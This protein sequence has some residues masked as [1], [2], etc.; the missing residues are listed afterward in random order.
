[1]KMIGFDPEAV[2]FFHGTITKQLSMVYD[3][4]GYERL[5]GL[6]T[7]TTKELFEMGRKFE[8]S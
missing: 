6:Y 3:R 4:V 2:E 8:H 1:M 5:G 7:P